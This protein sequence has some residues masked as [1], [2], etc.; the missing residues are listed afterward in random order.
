MLRRAKIQILA[1]DRATGAMTRKGAGVETCKASIPSTTGKTLRTTC[2]RDQPPLVAIGARDEREAPLQEATIEIALEISAHELWQRRARETV[3][4][5]GSRACS[6][7]PGP[8]PRER[9]HGVK[10]G[11]VAPGFRC[12]LESVAGGRLTSRRARS[13]TALPVAMVALQM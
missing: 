12:R 4:D 11:W 10:A 7:K 3:L 2:E 6:G 9:G 13:A 8:A 5:R 1:V